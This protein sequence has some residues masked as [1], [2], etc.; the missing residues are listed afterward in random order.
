VVTC[1]GTPTTVITAGSRVKLPTI[2][3]TDAE[4][5]ADATIGGGGTVDATF[6]AVE[7]GPIN[8]PDATV[9][10]IVTPIAGWTSATV[11]G[12]FSR[13]RDIELDQELRIR[14]GNSLALGGN[15]TPDAIGAAVQQLADVDFAVA[16]ENDTLITDAKGIPGKA[17]RVVVWPTGVNQ[18]RIIDT[19]YAVWPGGIFSDGSNRFTVLTSKG[20]EK[21]FGFDFATE[22]PIHVRVELNSLVGYGGDDAVKQTVVDFGA[23]SL[24]VGTDV[25]PADIICRIKDDVAGVGNPEVFIAKTPPPVLTE[26][27]PI[28]SDEIATIALVDVDI[29]IRL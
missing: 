22:V 2:D 17:M 15:A 26:T 19:M 10:T 21:E 27:I 23:D 8:Y 6:R 16:I 14:R 1:G 25:E 18:Q 5:L 3:D 20:Q 24:N 29:V 11:N 28:D 4:L 12:D 7:T 9:L 13:G